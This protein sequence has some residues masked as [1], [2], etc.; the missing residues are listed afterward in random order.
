MNILLIG[1]G[2]REHALAAAIARS[3]LCSRLFCA[4]GNAGIA[5]AAEIVKLDADDHAAVVA[6]CRDQRIG[7]V[8][9]GPEAPLVG[10]LADALAA[11]GISCFGPSKAA[12]Q[13]EGSK[14]FTKDLCARYGIPTAAYGR[15]T[16]L[17][18]RW[19]ICAGKARRSWSRPTGSP[20]ARA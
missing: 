2:G 16:E 7:F 14:G 11:A 3:P 17:S 18:R 10:G 15:F 13:L 6:F 12:A 9:I 1:S 20:P 4:P 19:H 8:V 5:D